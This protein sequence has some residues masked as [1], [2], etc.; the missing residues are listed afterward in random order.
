M[1]KNI[2]FSCIVQHET[3]NCHLY[4]L[5]FSDFILF[6][7][8][9]LACARTGDAGGKLSSANPEPD[10]PGLDGR[11][12]EIQG[13]PGQIRHDL[14]LIAAER[15]AKARA[16]LAA[17]DL[18]DQAVQKTDETLRKTRQTVRDAYSDL[19]TTGGE[20]GSEALSRAKEGGEKASQTVRKRVRQGIR[21]VENSDW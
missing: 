13:I 3:S 10:R 12:G 5:L 1:L 21:D 18:R 11:T 6:G 16:N 15:D 7:R 4:S 14:D 8:G 20:V 9:E 2:R 17:D 19:V